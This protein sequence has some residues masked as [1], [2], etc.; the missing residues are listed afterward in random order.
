MS[1]KRRSPADGPRHDRQTPDPRALW[2]GL[3]TSA[4]FLLDGLRQSPESVCMTAG[5]WSVLK[6]LALSLGTVG[7][8]AR[9]DLWT[10]TLS[11]RAI[12]RLQTWHREGVEVRLLVDSSLWR[13][14]P[15]YGAALMA[16]DFAGCVRA[17]SAHA[18]A[19]AVSG[20]SGSVFIAGSGNL[21]LCRRAELVWLSKD[22]A[23]A[24]WLSAVTDRAF[25]ALPAG[26]PAGPARHLAE[27]LAHALP[28]ATVRPA[29]A[30]GVPS[31]QRGSPR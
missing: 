15:A 17:A 27:R 25:D 5:A 29:W 11:R 26:A 2:A 19:A 22:P 3:H 7:R 21:N 14:Q 24:A 20:P 9:I 13:R 6:L 4:E 31:L 28:S 23:L 10:W 1:P 30:A 16:G 12:A 18:K 8:P